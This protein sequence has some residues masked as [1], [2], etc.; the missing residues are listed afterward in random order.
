MSRKS[1][2]RHVGPVLYQVIQ[3]GDRIAGGFAASRG[4]SPNWESLC[5]YLT[6]AIIVPRADYLA[7]LHP[8]SP[9]HLAEGLALIFG[10]VL[11]SGAL[12][13]L[14]LRHAPLFIAVTEQQ[15][16]CY[17]LTRLDSFPVR[18]KF[19]APLSA[20]RL[21]RGRSGGLRWRSLVVSAAGTEGQEIRLYVERKWRRDVAEALAAVEAG[22]GAVTEVGKNRFRRS[23]RT[24]TSAP[25]GLTPPE[26]TQPGLLAGGLALPESAHD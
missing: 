10:P 4:I 22:G 23:A 14:R 18:L 12:G 25:S 5:A 20:F 1:I 16:I 13:L 2:K 6:L 21:T 24:L 19:C 17:E 3:P 7:R 26:L 11:V 9:A 8:G 15:V